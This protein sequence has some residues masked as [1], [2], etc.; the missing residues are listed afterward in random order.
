VTTAAGS[1][2]TVA[3]P[4]ISINAVTV[5]SGLQVNSNG[6]LAAPAPTANFQV[7]LV[8]PNPNL[9][10][11]PNATTA[12]TGSITLTLAQGATSFSFYVQGKE[13]LTGT[14]SVTVTG[15]AAGF[16]NGTADM[17][18]VQGAIDLI[19]VPAS[20][21][22]L[23]PISNIYARTGIPNS[24]TTPSFLTQLQNVRFGAPGALTVNFLS[25]SAA[26]A[27]LLKAGPSASGSQS[28]TI[29]IGS[30]NTPT[31]TTSGGVAIRPLLSGTTTIRASITGFLQVTNAAGSPVSIAQPGITVN[32]TTVGSGLQVN[33]SGSLGAPNHG[34][35]TVR[36]ISSNGA[37]LLAPDANTPGTSF[38]DIVVPNG[39]QSFGFYLQGLEGQPD[40]V[41]AAITATASG[42]QETTV[43]DARLAVG[44]TLRVRAAFDDCPGPSRVH[45]YRWTTTNASVATVDSLG[46]VRAQARGVVTIVAA[47]VDA[48]DI[49]GA[50]V[51]NV[52]PPPP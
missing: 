43:T 27:D 21:T 23:S 32:G 46:L 12:G 49:E 30:S 52:D 29:P 13:G 24:Q 19:G 41:T 42:F 33:A 40:T 36:L 48:P 51:L 9:L 50:M 10:L 15:S 14:T 28:A 39:T 7:T 44:D 11:A 8:S 26:V 35:V 31:D 18:L 1:A 45:S 34:G 37:L 17:S 16:A 20:T 38:I 47:L 22:T 6:S 3:Q 4:T 2:V 5:G 25:T